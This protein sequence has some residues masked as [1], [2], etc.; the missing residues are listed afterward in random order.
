ML[1]PRVIRRRDPQEEAMDEQK[2]TVKETPKS[3]EAAPKKEQAGLKV[4]TS[5]RA[6]DDWEARV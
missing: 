1:D 3:R 5:V 4:K 6:G 2:K